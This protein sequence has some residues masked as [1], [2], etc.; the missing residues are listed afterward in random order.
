MALSDYRPETAEIVFKGGSF[1]VK[2]LT[3]EDVSSLIRTHLPDMESLFD[4]YQQ[5]AGDVF[6]NGAAERL[7]LKL[8][9]DAPALTANVI[10]CASGEPDSVDAARA[11][12]LPLQVRALTEIGRLTFEDAGGPKKFFESLMALTGNIIPPALIAGTNKKAR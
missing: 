12:S 2:G 6:A 5:S 7:I 8:A 1:N 3:L 4:M 11:L 10:A 9:K